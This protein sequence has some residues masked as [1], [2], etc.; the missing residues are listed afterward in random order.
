[1]LPNFEC[2]QRLNVD[3]M[4]CRC[5]NATAI[6]CIEFYAPSKV[7]VYFVINAWCSIG[8]KTLLQDF[9]EEEDK[10]LAK[11]YDQAWHTFF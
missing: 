11:K 5:L 3:T 9:V 1:M 4:Q 7:W 6:V 10:N 8:W 2:C